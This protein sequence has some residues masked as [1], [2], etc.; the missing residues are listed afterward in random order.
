MRKVD[1]GTLDVISQ[2]Q[3]VSREANKNPKFLQALLENHPELANPII[4]PVIQALKQTTR[5]KKRLLEV[6]TGK[7][8]MSLPTSCGTSK[9]A[10]NKR[11]RTSKEF[12]VGLKLALGTPL[13][14]TMCHLPSTPATPALPSRLLL[15]TPAPANLARSEPSELQT[16]VL[17]TLH[18]NALKSQERRKGKQHV[19]FQLGA[20]M[21]PSKSAYLPVLPSSTAN[22]PASTNARSS[23]VPPQTTPNSNKLWDEPESF[24]PL[25]TASPDSNVLEMMLE[26]PTDK[27]EISPTFLEESPTASSPPSSPLAAV[28]E[29][30]AVM[31]KSSPT[32]PT[33]SRVAPASKTESTTDSVVEDGR[34]SPAPPM[35][36]T[37]VPPIRDLSMTPTPAIQH[38]APRTDSVV[39]DGCPSPAPPMPTTVVPPI[40]DLSMTPTPA[41]QHPAPRSPPKAE[42]LTPPQSPR[43]AKAAPPPKKQTTRTAKTPPKK[44][45]PSSKKRKPISSSAKKRGKEEK[46]Q[47]QQAALRASFDAVIDHVNGLSKARERRPFLAAAAAKKHKKKTVEEVFGISITHDEWH[48]INVHAIYPGPFVEATR[49]PFSRRKVKTDVLVKL[50]QYLDLP[51][52]LQK[53]AV[54][55]KIVAICHETSFAEL[56]NVARSKKLTRLAAEYVCSLSAELDNI[57]LSQSDPAVNNLPESDKR[58]QHIEDSTFRRCMCPRGHTEDH[59][60]TPKGSICLTTAMELIQS[61]TFSEIKRLTGLDDIKVSKGRENFERMRELAKI[62]CPA[63]TYQ[64]MATRIDDHELFCQT[65]LTLHFKPVGGHSCNCLTCGFFSDG[66]SRMS[67][68]DRVSRGM[69]ILGGSTFVV[70]VPPWNQSS[71]SLN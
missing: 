41:I 36:T 66:K 17:Q 1:F 52:N 58:C 34:P 55:R 21:T 19:S 25:Q 7:E 67:Q 10:R 30:P 63:D 11:I 62:Y 12:K 9:A 61:M 33:I 54:G 70:P 8:N 6:V 18:L 64:S 42:D 4:E 14:K 24:V 56:D 60:F 45:A 71:D 69:P 46:L 26:S 59:K 50:L 51:G 43:T 49:K 15:L 16:P 40:R 5:G 44:K 39:K 23:F 20:P 47:S 31:F 28:E 48:K 53:Y 57:N 32:T 3:E 22:K 27:F 37:V 2:C 35:P 29:I 13:V 65:D 38:P 68:I